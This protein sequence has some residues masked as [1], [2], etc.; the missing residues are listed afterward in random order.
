MIGP[1]VCIRSVR[2]SASPFASFLLK[3]E[4]FEDV[5]LVAEFA[6]WFSLLLMPFEEL[7]LEFRGVL[8]E[9]KGDEGSVIVRWVGK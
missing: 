7:Q 2:Q 9:W 5:V 1:Y 6:V 4:L 8:L 3:V